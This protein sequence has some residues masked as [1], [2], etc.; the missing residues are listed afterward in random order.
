MASKP[1]SNSSVIGFI[2]LGA[3]GSPIARRLIEAGFEL[4]VHD[5]R[6]QAMRPFTGRA[7]LAN[8]CA[9]VGE[10]AEV[11]FGCLPGEGAHREAILGVTGLVGA[12]RVRLYVN[13]ER[14]AK[15]YCSSSRGAS[16]ALEL[17]RLTPR[18]RAAFHAPN[19]EP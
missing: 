5:V 13:L 10:Q 6:S 4:V 12:R 16:S 7:R 19:R 17:Q 14:W 15:R 11:V 1:S 2:G 8:S 18:S 3:I 9:E